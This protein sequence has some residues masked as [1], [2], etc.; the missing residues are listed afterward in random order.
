MKPQPIRDFA[1]M[2]VAAVVAV[3]AV[4]FA[5]PLVALARKRKA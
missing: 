4:I 3:F 1:W 2:T 5:E